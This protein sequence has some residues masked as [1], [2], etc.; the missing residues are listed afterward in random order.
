MLY[1]EIVA[2]CVPYFNLRFD[3][4]SFYFKD[5]SLQT[6]RT[7]KRYVLKKPHPQATVLHGCSGKAHDPMLALKNLLPFA[8]KAIGCDS[9]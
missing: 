1:T 4:T 8:L 2:S 5:Y 7:R 9:T 3:K 6:V